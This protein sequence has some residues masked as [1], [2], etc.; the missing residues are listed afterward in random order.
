MLIRVGFFLDEGALLDGVRRA[1][2]KDAFPRYSIA[3]SPPSLLVIPLDVFW[4][5][6]VDDEAYVWLVNAHPEGN[7]GA[8][9][10][11]FVAE[12]LFLSFIANP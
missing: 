8:D 4:Q 2:K 12:E 3:S 10:P 7:G 9:D 6:K 1:V 5:I 11:D